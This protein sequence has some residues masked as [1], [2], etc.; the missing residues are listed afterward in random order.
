MAITVIAGAQ[1][2]D[3][4]KGKL[5]DAL[6]R[7]G[8]AVV[9]FQGGANAGH[10]VRTDAGGF[11]FHMLP[12][13]VLRA[14][15]TN[16]IAS[17]VALDPR[18][19]LAELEQ[20]RGAGVAEPRLAIS[21]RARVVLEGH[22]RLD[23]LEEERLG[24]RAFGSTRRGIAPLYA[25]KALKCAIP[26]GCCCDPD[27]VA[28][29]AG[30]WVDWI[31]DL[32]PRRHHAAPASVDAVV[33]EA[34][35][36]HA[37]LAPW[38]ADTGALLRG[39]LARGQRILGEAQ[40]GALRD[41]DHGVIPWTTSTSTLASA[42]AP[43]AGLPARAIETVIAA[44][45]CYSSCVGAGPMPTEVDGAAAAHLRRFG[46]ERGSTTGRI[47]RVGWC[48]LVASR[49]GCDLQAADAVA[50]TMLDVLSGL[51]EILVCEAYLLDGQRIETLPPP[52][53]LPR[54]RPCWRAM[55]GW[56]E[57]LAGCARWAD[58][59][60]AAQAYVRAIAQLLGRR[61]AWAGVG[62]HRDQLLEVP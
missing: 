60:A 47:R 7:E 49:H 29:A 44:V 38:V 43:A 23:A 40:L 11:A 33:A 20:L 41:V 27:A 37:A 35:S 36:A 50:L 14:D 16:V 59:P 17:G 3:E 8:D 48:D 21:D 58:L 12:C 4:G 55:P 32:M 53:L 61:I 45:K 56:G 39:G 1:W 54:C 42:L 30:R 34:Q 52:H 25:T 46:H 15:T 28:A 24:A 22:M 19:L 26:L 62:A 6:A 9:R 18:S 13:G 5:V 2:G 31:G 51:D 57:E 10:S